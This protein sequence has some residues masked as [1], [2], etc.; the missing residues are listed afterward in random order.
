MPCTG[1]GGTGGDL[2]EGTS[3][4]EQAATVQKIWDRPS[5]PGSHMARPRVHGRDGHTTHRRE[6]AMASH[7]CSIGRDI[8]V[9]GAE[10]QSVR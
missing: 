3:G 2:P 6:P 4:N 5:C 7:N 10:K 9:R 8:P 1:N